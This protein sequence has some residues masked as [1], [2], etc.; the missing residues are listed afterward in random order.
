MYNM[1]D[2]CLEFKFKWHNSQNTTYLARPSGTL[3]VCLIAYINKK[4]LLNMLDLKL[5]IEL[6]PQGEF[7]GLWFSYTLWYV[8]FRKKLLQNS[9]EALRS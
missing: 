2:N 6:A 5:A 7:S 3:D 4:R 9:V 1:L 8:A